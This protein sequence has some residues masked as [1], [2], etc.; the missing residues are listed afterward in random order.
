MKFATI[1]SALALTALS[2]GAP[3]AT[4]VAPASK[5]NLFLDGKSGAL[6]STDYYN[7]TSNVRFVKY[8]AKD[9]IVAA[10]TGTTN[11]AVTYG[12]GV[13]GN[14]VSCGGTNSCA[15]TSE[16]GYDGQCVSFAKAMT[17]VVPTKNWHRGLS[18]PSAIDTLPRDNDCLL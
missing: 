3:A 1:V 9:K 17:K 15:T 16:S 10:I 13:G 8:S 2:M 14:A 5:I 7:P 4:Y 18:L 11:G 6:A 12:L